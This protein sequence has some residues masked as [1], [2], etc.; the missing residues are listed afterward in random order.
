MTP[1]HKMRMKIPIQKSISPF[2]KGGEGDLCFLLPRHSDCATNPFFIKNILK[3]ENRVIN[4]HIM[5]IYPH[6]YRKI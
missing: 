2:S 3:V 5:V 1:V 6:Y 4:F